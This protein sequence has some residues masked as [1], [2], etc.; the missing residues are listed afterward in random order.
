MRKIVELF[1]DIRFEEFLRV[2]ISDNALS[3]VHINNNKVIKKIDVELIDKLKIFDYIKER[4]ALPLEIIISSN[5]ISCRSITLEGLRE[6]DMISLAHNVIDGKN[7]SVNLICYEKKFSYRKGSAL[8]CDMKLTPITITI[9]QEAIKIGNL[10]SAIAAWPFWLVSSFF[11]LHSADVGKFKGSIF[12]TKQH[13][14]WEVIAL[15]NEK[16]V[17][18]RKGLLDGFDEIC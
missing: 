4:K 15:H 8:F 11:R 18:Y 12:V 10:I 16:H 1:R 13:N 14:S 5:T 6:K 9:L 7:G 2:V 3:L 17:Y